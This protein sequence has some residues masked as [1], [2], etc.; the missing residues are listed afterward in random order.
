[1]LTLL[2]VIPMVLLKNEEQA[3]QDPAGEVFELRRKLNETF[4]PS[5]DFVPFVVESRTGDMLT[6]AA[7]QELFQN[8]AKLRDLDRQRGL[9]AGGL[10]KQPYLFTSVDPDSGIRIDGVYTLADAVNDRLQR[11]SRLGASLATAGDEQ[12]KVAVH[13]VLSNPSTRGFLNSLSV[14]STSEAR[15]IGGETIDWWVSPA[16]VDGVRADNEKLGGGGLEIG[17]GGDETVL[18]KERFARQVQEVM[19]GRENAYRLWGIAIDVNLESADEGQRAG[20]F[21]MFTVIGAVAIAGL[22]LKSY[23]ATALTGVGIGAL[24]IW[25]KGIS[26]LVGLEGGLIIDL[27]V[28]IAMISLGV[29]YAIHAVHRYQEEKTRE[30][31]FRAALRVGLAGVLG[32]LTLAMLTDGLAFASNASSG[33]EAVTQFG[34]A[35]AV[36]VLSAWI[37]LGM[38]VPA[39]VMRIDQLRARRAV[40]AGRFNRLPQLA[41]AAGVAALSGTSVIL[42]VAVSPLVGTGIL[43]M[44]VVVFLGVP[45]LVMSRRRPSD[46]G[47]EPAARRPST[48]SQPEIGLPERALERSIVTL[49]RYRYAVL[50]AAVALTAICSYFAFKLDATLDVK[51][52]FDSSSDF[53]VSLDKID[54]HVAE[55]SGEP[56]D[57][58]IEGDLTDPASLRAIRA[59][60]AKLDE[61]PS[62]AQ[63]ADGKP[64]IFTATIIGI[65]E[66]T[67]ST[68]FAVAEVERATGL[69]PEDLDRDGLPDT[70]QQIKAVYEYVLANGVPVD[71]AGHFF[72]TPGQVREVISHDSSGSGSDATWLALGIPGTREQTNVVA[73][74]DRLNDDLDVLRQAPGLTRYGVTGSPFTRQAQLDA[75]TN[76]LQSSIPLAAASSFVLLL[77]AMR[78]LRYALVTII[79][80]GLVVAWLYALM[81]LTGFALN[82]VTATIGSVS[83]GVGIDYSI[84]VTERYREELRRTGDRFEALVTA[85]RGTGIALGGSAGS[86]IVGFAIMGFA[87]MPLFSS[88]GILTATMIALALTASLLV[89]PSL[90]VMVTPARSAATVRASAAAPGGGAAP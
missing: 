49:A 50:P 9:S 65:L 76:S 64:A 89:L 8:E 30:R 46:A 67:M 82:F 19:R 13:R 5:I 74:R 83:I 14:K 71:A 18:N 77:V 28:P 85:A 39:A 32:A 6:A 26:N 52:F 40:M 44:T 29:D 33:I 42:M 48:G 36:A 84:H 41:A 43:V 23:W 21:I 51:D 38:I 37:V 58:L 86:S 35:A 69:R 22:S 2:L 70:P 68:P 11:D 17:L 47:T 56:A 78:S 60:I 25:L 81:Y 80:I 31:T 63:Q 90:L 53:V 79:P 1:M 88:Y 27:I 12:V 62:V 59:F 45:V 16:L 73:A 61:N 20:V 57:V 10:P 3:S 55:R 34:I 66:R 72:Y 87:P 75:T 54:E 7:L 15:T 24:I 4:S